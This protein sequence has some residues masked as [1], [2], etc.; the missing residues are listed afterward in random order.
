MRVE[1]GNFLV[2][3]SKVRANDILALFLNYLTESFNVYDNTNPEQ[4][5][6]LAKEWMLYALELLA[7]NLLSKDN[8]RVS[9]VSRVM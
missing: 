5:D 4:R 7:P 2:Y 3:L 6:F 9:V 1:A 8:L